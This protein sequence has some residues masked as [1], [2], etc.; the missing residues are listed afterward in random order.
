M[1]DDDADLKRLALLLLATIEAS[2]GGYVLL[3][4]GTMPLGQR[5]IRVNVRHHGEEHTSRSH[6]PIGCPATTEALARALDWLRRQPNYD[7]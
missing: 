1:S 4:F 5:E 7:P 2:G 6:A 3:R